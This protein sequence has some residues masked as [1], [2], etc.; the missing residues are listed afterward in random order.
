MRK[1]PLFAFIL[2]SVS[3]LSGSYY[4]TSAIGIDSSSHGL[5]YGGRVVR[6]YGNLGNDKNLFNKRYPRQPSGLQARQQD[7]EDSPGKGAG[8]GGNNPTAK[9]TDADDPPKAKAKA[10]EQPAASPKEAPAKEPSPK[11][12]PKEQP[13]KAKPDP[14]KQPPKAKATQTQ[15]QQPDSE[16]DES[17]TT[18]SSNGVNAA[19]ANE[20]A[21]PTD[22]QAGGGTPTVAIGGLSSAALAGLASIGGVF[23][24]VAGLFAFGQR[25]KN[26]EMTKSIVSTSAKA[27]EQQNSTYEKMEEEAEPIGSYTVIATYTPTLADELD[28]QPGD[29]VTILVEFDDGWV[30]GINETR[31]GTKGV[32]PRHCVDMDRVSP[33]KNNKRSSSMGVFSEKYTE[34]DL[35]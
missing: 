4:Q 15:N 10:K 12:Q 35:S 7:P 18:P 11:E 21:A 30:Q 17:D 2:V 13:T 31:G 9:G 16:S 33:Y 20:Q 24:L 32:F 23:V 25:K 5:L 14:T 28:I 6:R 22:T 34:V 3:L 19:T 8:K 26:K 27:W 1:I 29:K